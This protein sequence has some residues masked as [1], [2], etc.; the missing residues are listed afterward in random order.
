MILQSSSTTQKPKK[1]VFDRSFS[2]HHRLGK[3]TIGD[4]RSFVF[5]GRP[6]ENK[7]IIAD[8][9]ARDR[10][11]SIFLLQKIKAHPLFGSTINSKSL[12]FNFK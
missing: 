9:V 2:D 12:L 4:F 6:F 1:E 7:K 3:K 10:V 8:L 11:T 5:S